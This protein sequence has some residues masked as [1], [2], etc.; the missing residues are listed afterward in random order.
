MHTT[1]RILFAKTLNTIK[2]NVER[3]INQSTIG[4]TSSFK[5]RV[6][7]TLTELDDILNRW[8]NECVI[9]FKGDDIH[10]GRHLHSLEISSNKILSVVDRFNYLSRIRNRSNVFKG[11]A[12][13]FEKNDIDIII[14]VRDNVKYIYLWDV[15]NSGMK[16]IDMYDGDAINFHNTDDFIF[17]K[18]YDTVKDI[19]DNDSTFKNHHYTWLPVHLQF[20]IGRYL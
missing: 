9:S 16:L 13:T 19:C 20:M 14:Y 7:D 4:M 15:K 3:K 1:N 12:K 5:F 8:N 6:I 10:V 18:M 2:G 11:I 17:R